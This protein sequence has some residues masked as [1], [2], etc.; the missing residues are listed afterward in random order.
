M[1]KE[2]SK[3]KANKNNVKGIQQRIINS[4]YVI[5]VISF[6]ASVMALVMLGYMGGQFSAFHKGNYR[7]TVET[8][9]V[10]YAQLS[11]RSAL[12]SAM[13]DDD[14]KVTNE[15]IEASVNYLEEMGTLLN[16]MK[17]IYSGDDSVIDTINQQREE[18]LLVVDEMLEYTVYGHYDKAYAVMK[19]KYV[20]KVDQIAQLL[21]DIAIE[22]DAGAV[23]KV[24]MVN[25]LMVIMIVMVIVVIVIS[26]IVAIKLGTKI[27]KGIS[28]PVKEI[29]GAAKQLA[30]GNLN[31][32]ISYRATDELGRLADSMRE[33]CNFMKEVV[34]DA[35]YLLHEIAGGNFKVQT[36]KK[37]VYIGDFQGL[38]ESIDRLRSQLSNTLTEINEASVQVSLG[39]EQLALGAQSLAEGAVDQAGAVQELTAMVNGVNDASQ[40]T[41]GITNNSYK[42][43]TEFKKEVEAGQHEMSNLLNAMERIKETSNNIEKIIAEIEDIAS[44]TNLLSLN[45]S[46]EAARAGE[47]GRGFAVVADQVGK[48]AADCA[49]SSVNTKK[50]IQQAIEEVENGNEIAY[51]TSETL[52]K[53]ADGIDMLASSVQEVNTNTTDQAEAISQVELGIEQI[54]TVIENNSAAAEETSATSEEL[55][56]QAGRLKGLVGQFILS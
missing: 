21:E 52:E 45:A 36:A 28:E 44:Q 40:V 9:K 15:Q 50:L 26:N 4:Y 47:A 18:A 32:E 46:I 37:E 11:A 22:E 33:S 10:R 42:Q 19:E 56:A 6:I 31:V 16:G 29:E 53:V 12:L 30:E 2:N 25:T 35:D 1:K 43:A 41:V 23:E 5:I 38:L 13:V 48:L 54:T 34:T 55:S 39:A 14:L 7:V 17:E 51:R 20:P 8:W 24:N 49:Q 27:A 3:T